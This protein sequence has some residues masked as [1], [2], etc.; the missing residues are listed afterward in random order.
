MSASELV[1][2]EDIGGYYDQMG[3]LIEIME[4][5]IHVGYWTSDD[6]PTPLL[7]AINRLT[8]IVGEALDLQPGE[9]AIDIGCGVGRRR[10]GSPSGSRPGSPASRSAPGRY[11]RRPG[12]CAP[13]ACAGRS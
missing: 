6:D 3:G 11:R 1:A 7:E 8:D 10:S 9:H 13:P 12:G 2:V 4:G 5:N